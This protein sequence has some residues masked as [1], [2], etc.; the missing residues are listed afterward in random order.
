MNKYVLQQCC[1]W[2]QVNTMPQAA[3]DVEEGRYNALTGVASLTSTQMSEA[4]VYAGTLTQTRAGSLND[5]IV[6]LLDADVPWSRLLGKRALYHLA[7]TKNAAVGSKDETARKCELEVLGN[8]RLG[9]Q[10][11]ELGRHLCAA[12]YHFG[13]VA[14]S[15]CTSHDKVTHIAE[16]YF[17]STIAAYEFAWRLDLAIRERLQKQ[18]PESETSTPNGDQ[19]K[20][21]ALATLYVEHSTMTGHI[22]WD[23]F[24]MR[25]VKLMEDGRNGIAEDT[26]REGLNE[27][28][29]SG[30]NLALAVQITSAETDVTALTATHVLTQLAR[31]CVQDNNLSKLL[32][33]LESS[34]NLGQLLSEIFNRTVHSTPSSSLF[35]AQSRTEHWLTA[36]FLWD[37][38]NWVYAW[39]VMQNIV[40]VY[41][42]ETLN[43]GALKHLCKVAHIEDVA[44]D[45]LDDLAP[46]HLGTYSSCHLHALQDRKL[47]VYDNKSP[48]QSFTKA[49]SSTLSA[50]SSD[51]GMIN[52]DKPMREYDDNNSE[53]DS[54]ANNSQPV[55]TKVDGW[56][57]GCDA[58]NGPEPPSTGC[59]QTV[60][61]GIWD[62][63]SLPRAACGHMRTVDVVGGLSAHY[64]SITQK[65]CMWS[66]GMQAARR[67]GLVITGRTTPNPGIGVCYAISRNTNDLNCHERRD[68]LVHVYAYSKTGEESHCFACMLKSKKSML[69]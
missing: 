41:H 5:F 42:I 12:L 33:I 14:Y 53:T 36:D 18:L 6:Y 59:C 49:T 38:H 2:T 55:Q 10:S 47:H 26:L 61:D 20:Q 63:K 9:R 54:S 68:T 21:E 23:L 25:L 62:T 28:H 60:L 57:I 65:G 44:L 16:L 37:N 13:R 51:P 40:E 1:Y 31:G 39:K 32:G 11:L 46:A 43:R 30:N 52:S 67:N 34:A 15:S 66:V 29:L 3:A 48:P 56:S 45:V 27:C 22:W 64:T 7:S 50:L 4:V 17:Q 19:V 35:A 58:L 8:T 69:E 24:P